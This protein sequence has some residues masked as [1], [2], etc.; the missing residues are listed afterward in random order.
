ML[1][2]PEKLNTLVGHL[3][4]NKLKM[5]QREEMVWRCDL[6]SLKSIYRILL[7]HIYFSLVYSGSS[8]E[9]SRLNIALLSA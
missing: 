3:A 7:L 5:M 9:K 8:A 4:I 6:Y 2:M 1:K